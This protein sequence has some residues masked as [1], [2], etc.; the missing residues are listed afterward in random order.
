MRQKMNGNLL[1]MIKCIQF[2]C[3]TINAWTLAQAGI[4]DLVAGH[5]NYWQAGIDV[6]SKEAF[7]GD[8]CPSTNFCPPI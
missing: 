2:L 4:V 3:A 6:C 5:M 1:V 7:W 8:L